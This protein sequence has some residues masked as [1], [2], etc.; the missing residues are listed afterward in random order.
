V[1]TAGG[2]SHEQELKTKVRNL[3]ESRFGGDYRKAFECY[4]RNSDGGIDRDEVMN[5]LRQAGV[6]S[7]LT[8][9]AWADG[10]LDRLDTNH[11]GRVEW[12][13][14]QRQVAAASSPLVAGLQPPRS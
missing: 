4:D 5:V 1:T 8:R 13:E 11:N 12:R 9:G 7:G 6:G 2:T 14:F 10:A 3:V